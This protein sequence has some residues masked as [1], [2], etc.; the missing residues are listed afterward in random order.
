MPTNYY[1]SSEATLAE[2]VDEAWADHQDRELPDSERNI[3]TKFLIYAFDLKNL[4]HDK[5]HL[6]HA[7]KKLMDMRKQKRAN[8]PNYV[9]ILHSGSYHFEETARILTATAI[10]YS[11]PDSSI[12]DAFDQGELLDV[13][14][15][16][17]LL[18]KS[19]QPTFLDAGQRTLFNLDIYNGLFYRDGK[20]FD[21]S[22]SISHQ[23]PKYVAF[24][25][26]TNGELSAFNHL[27]G[28]IDEQGQKFV[29]SSMNSGAPVLIAGELEI[30]N[31][32][33]ITITSFS[34]HYKPT[35]FNIARFLEYLA[36]RGMDLTHTQVLLFHPPHPDS[37]LQSTPLKMGGAYRTWHRIG[38]TD[39]IKNITGVIESHIAIMQAYLDSKKTKFKQK[40]LKIN[41]TLVKVALFQELIDELNYVKQ[42]MKGTPKFTVLLESLAVID[43]ILSGF[44]EAYK[45]LRPRGVG[46]VGVLFEEMR[47]RTQ[48]AGQPFECIDEAEEQIRFGIYKQSR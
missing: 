44:Q 21:S 1:D 11:S 13:S 39:I 25:L 41:A 3:A 26:N 2:R 38:A 12:Q 30:Q 43:F 16:S 20:I 4:S 15:K 5:D 10:S 34:D 31:G 47:K 24:T 42:T 48:Q 18:D 22:H 33:L 14:Q 8:N 7:L 37:G 28:D 36:D 40:L 35:L 19:N 32:Q 6:N 17:K 23:K 46:R 29:H 45:E 27:E 9:P